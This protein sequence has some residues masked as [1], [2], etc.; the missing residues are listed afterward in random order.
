M[1]GNE[2][3]I[4]EDRG[5]LL[6]NS[7]IQEEIKVNE[8]PESSHSSI[9]RQVINQMESDESERGWSDAGGDGGNPSHPGESNERFE[10][11]MG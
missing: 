3:E 7:G 5:N 9:Q 6:E 4:A 1:H 2:M 8:R 11:E 10:N